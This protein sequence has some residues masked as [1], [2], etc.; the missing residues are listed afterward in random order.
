MLDPQPDSFGALILRESL[1]GLD[2]EAACPEALI[3]SRLNL[4]VDPQKG[5]LDP[6]P[7]PT[8]GQ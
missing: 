4:G 6:E 1:W 2:P 7:P 3:L 8:L 5:D